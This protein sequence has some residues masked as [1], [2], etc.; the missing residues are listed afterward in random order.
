MKTFIRLTSLILCLT[1]LLI[2]CRSEETEIVNPPNEEVTGANTNVTNLLQRTALNDGSYDNII[3]GAN[4]F[5]IQ[6]PVTVIVNGIEVVVNNE[7][8]LDT[9]EDIL[10]E[11]EDDVDTLE[12]IFPITI[13]LEDYTQVVINSQEELNAAAVQCPGENEVDDD[14]ECIDIQYPITVSIFNQNNELIDSFAINND[15]ELFDFIDDLDDDTI[16]TLNFPITIILSDGTTQQIN[17]FDELEAAIETAIDDCDEDDDNDDDD[18]DCEDCDIEEIEGLL[19]ECPEWM[20]DKLERNDQD[21][22]DNYVGYEFDFQENDV[23]EVDFNGTIFTGTW[24]I[25]DN[26]DE[27]EVEIDLPQLTD[28]NDNWILHE[29]EEEEDE[30]QIDLRLGDDRL[31]FESDC[32]DN[33]GGNT[34]DDAALIAAL[35]TGD[36]YVT[37]YFDDVDETA[38]FAD[39]V[40]NFAEDNTATATDDQGT[41]NGVWTTD[42][43]DETELELNLN[44]GTGIPLDELAEDWDVLEFNDD[45]IRLKDVSGGDGTEEFLT[46]E[47]EPF[48]G[49]G[50]G[51][52]LEDII[53][54]GT[55]IVA[56]YTEDGIDESAPFIGYDLVFDLSG[57]VEA[58]NGS[59][60]NNGTWEVASAGNKF[61]LDFGVQ[62]PFEEFNDDWDVLM[63]SDTRV[64]LQDVSGGNGGTDILVFEKI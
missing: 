32:I 55:W 11:F 34:A 60:T 10:E 54:D 57:D 30:T 2:S 7:D 18:D 26:G 20:V 47:R 51:S 38:D 16:F 33:G 63:V 52:D 9:I 31:R 19:I 29:F 40:F 64:E 1:F 35:T 59:N 12:I 23:L 42:N 17:N 56:S 36:W 39:Y 22:E 27:I 46:F 41:T 45:I 3:D 44:F 58:T 4:C 25:F 13:I 14:I 53:T 28:F 21:L 62:F 8:D 50:G 61:I 15:E 43:G 24:D 49:G 48:T 6:L 5:D 37:Y